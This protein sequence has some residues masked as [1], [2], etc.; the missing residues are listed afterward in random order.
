IDCA[1]VRVPRDRTGRVP[2]TVPLHV[3]RVKALRP[4][5]P[6]TP[7]SAVVGL[8]GGPGQSALPLVEDFYPT[9]SAAPTTR[10]LLAFQRR[11]PS[12]GAPPLGRGIKGIQS[13]AAAVGARRPFFT[14][15]DSADDI[16]AVR[17]AA[18]VDKVVPYG[19]SYGT[20]VGLEYAH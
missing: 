4:P 18:G 7:R 10:G 6:G 13:C 3:F 5:P 9:I 8:A 19:T 16:D 14:T 12:P 17:Q 11:C 20:K 2:G 15:R 1:I